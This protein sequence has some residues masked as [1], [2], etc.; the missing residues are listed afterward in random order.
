MT[1]GQVSHLP[2]EIIFIILSLLPVKCLL[3]FRSVCKLWLM[4]TSDPKFVKTHLQL[5]ISNETKK[6]IVFNK[7]PTCPP[8]RPNI[9]TID[10]ET[11]DR[12]LLNLP[13]ASSCEKAEILGSCNG[14]LLVGVGE[15][16]HFLWNPST[17][18]KY[19]EISSR[20]HFLDFER[21][22]GLCYDSST[23]AY[24]MVR[25]VR[26]TSLWN[27][28]DQFYDVTHANFY[29]CKT[30]SWKKIEPFPYKLFTSAQG[31]LVNGNPH[32]VVIR[33]TYTGSSRNNINGS[34]RN[35]DY[36]VIYFDVVEDKFKEVAKPE[37]LDKDSSFDLGNFG[38]MLCLVQHEIFNPLGLSLNI[39]L[40]YEVWN[41]SKVW[42]M[43][44]YGVRDSWTRL[45][46]IRTKSRKLVPLCFRNNGEIMLEKDKKELATYSFA[47][48]TSREV[49]SYIDNQV[50]FSSAAYL[51]SL[52]SPLDGE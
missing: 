7:T 40:Q 18:S 35:V 3:R 49:F 32:Y 42:V 33:E 28:P 4:I 5:A 15:K 10:Y 24:K 16:S 30:K 36:V 31:V 21:L 51:E 6:H 37:W 34:T 48:E 50:G 12:L 20:T 17:S 47:D 44:D 2:E 13:F 29:N 39:E 38:G 23:D 1:G 52:V 43:R 25:V 14:L 27:H 8:Y 22:Y 11:H 9:T 41:I 19:L 26:G 46:T 45:F